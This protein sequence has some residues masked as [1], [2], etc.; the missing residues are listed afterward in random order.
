MDQKKKIM[1]LRDYIK[2]TKQI[3]EYKDSPS[4]ANP[5]A[6][7][8]KLLGKI[9]TPKLENLGQ[10]T[11]GSEGYSSLRHD[12]LTKWA[13]A[14][15]PFLKC[16]DAK[17]QIQLPNE[18][19]RPHL[20]FLGY[21]LEQVCESLPGLKNISHSLHRPGIDVWRLFVAIDDQIDGQRFV[22]NN[23]DWS[24]NAGDC[25]RLNNWQALHWT[26]NNS[27]VA[28]SIIKITGIKT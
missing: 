14:T 10:P 18:D 7:G 11:A 6:W 3:D 13:R 25:I 4:L 23:N 21:Y 26:Q 9:Q 15:W 24:W 5:N 2:W 27:Q 17:I 1:Y 16:L 28:R 19:C 22:I 8:F 12:L 20:D